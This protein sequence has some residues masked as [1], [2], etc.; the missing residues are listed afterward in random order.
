[1][2][3]SSYIFYRRFAAVFLKN[4][5]EKC[6]ARAYL[7]S[8]RRRRAGEDDSIQGL[9]NMRNIQGFSKKVAKRE[10]EHLKS[11]LQRYISEFV[12]RF[13]SVG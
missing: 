3:Y 5:N 13:R 2:K 4:L 1:M 10:R 8:A 7:L 6:F 12:I 9:I 11:Y